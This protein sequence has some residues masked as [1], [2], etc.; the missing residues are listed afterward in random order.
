MTAKEYFMALSDEQ[1]LGVDYRAE[2]R[3]DQRC[4]LAIAPAGGVPTHSWRAFARS[5]R[6]AAVRRQRIEQ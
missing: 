2:R 4:R 1:C 5:R 6:R 3:D